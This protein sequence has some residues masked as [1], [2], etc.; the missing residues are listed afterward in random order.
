MPWPGAMM[1]GVTALRFRPRRR[2]HDFAACQLGRR[3]PGR[4]GFAFRSRGRFDRGR[5]ACLPDGDRDGRGGFGFVR[6]RR[7]RGGLDYFGLRRRRN[8]FDHFRLWRELAACLFDGDR[9][10]RGGLDD[11]HLRRRRSGFDHFRLWRGLA[12]CLFDGDRVG[13]GGFDDIHLRRR[14]AARLLG[15][16]RLRRYFFGLRLRRHR[17][18]ALVGGDFARRHHDDRRHF[19]VRDDRQFGRR[20]LADVDRDGGVGRGRACNI[21]CSGRTGMHTGDLFRRLVDRGLG[22]RDDLRAHERRR[23][24]GRVGQVAQLAQRVGAPERGQDEELPPLRML[25][26]RDQGPARRRHGR[27]DMRVRADRRVKRQDQDSNGEKY[28]ANRNYA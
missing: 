21:A 14:R 19:L 4:G 22:R 20:A 18:R 9:G 13:R 28:A 12:A 3:R 15:G 25:L 6:L 27:R 26:A 16:R 10:G 23:A 7:R 2:Q 8:G 24:R 1:G 5:A 17:R 11:F